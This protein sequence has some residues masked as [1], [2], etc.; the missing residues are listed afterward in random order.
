MLMHVV[1]DLSD[2]FDLIWFD[3]SIW[4]IWLGLLNSTDEFESDFFSV[5]LFD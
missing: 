4:L 1:T 2:L 5:Y 3:R